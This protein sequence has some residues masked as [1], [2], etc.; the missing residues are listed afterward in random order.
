M[1]DL[2]QEELEQEILEWAQEYARKNGWVLNSN[3]DQLRTVIRGLA[4]N[5]LRFGERYCPCRI[6]SGDPEEDRKII[7]PC[8]YHR[9]EVENEGQCHCNLYFGKKED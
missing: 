6:R 2:S 5:S 1:A 9:D 8:I 3:D 4:R 7:C